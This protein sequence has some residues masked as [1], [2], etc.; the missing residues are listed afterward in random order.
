MFFSLNTLISI[1]CFIMVLFNI[2]LLLFQ[3]NIEYLTYLVLLLYLGGI[4]IFFLFTALML[5]QEYIS[6]KVVILYSLENSFL[7]LLFLKLFFYLSTLNYQ[8]CFFKIYFS[9]EYVPVYISNTYFLKDLL[10]NHGDALTF[11]SLYSEKALIFIIFGLI[12][13]FTMMGVILITKK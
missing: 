4:L 6:T 12:L 8:L 10:G 2:C 9:L 13:L 7:I 1:F 3:L 11:L 5:N